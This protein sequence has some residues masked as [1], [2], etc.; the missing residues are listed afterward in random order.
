MDTLPHRYSA[1]YFRQ[2]AVSPTFRLELAAFEHLLNT[3]PGRGDPVVEAGA[4]SGVLAVQLAD[5][6][7]TVVAAD[8]DIEPL[9]HL[10]G[11]AAQLLQCDVGRLPIATG[12]V[13]AV[14]AQ[15][16]IE[17][18]ADPV[19]VLREWRRVLRPGGACIVTTPNRHFPDQSW[20][21][22]PTHAEL[23]DQDRLLAVFH[24]AGFQRP[25]VLPLVPWLGSMRTVF[26]SAR[27]QRRL[28]PLFI[29]SRRSLNLLAA[30]FA[31]VNS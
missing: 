8:I 4:G 30:G 7:R 26:L 12:S 2:R 20:F 14:V 5:S 31:L 17:H 28:L 11:R 15:H 3:V 9:R 23:F 27:I 29:R 19:A 13:N 22:D 24:E 18:F 1:E 21:E 25:V 16:V 6:G 10:R